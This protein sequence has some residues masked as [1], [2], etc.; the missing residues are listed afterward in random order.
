[1]KLV[2]TRAPRLQPLLDKCQ[3]CGHSGCVVMYD[4]KINQIHP[5]RVVVSSVSLK[6]R[7]CG[8]CAV[9]F[10]ALVQGNSSNRKLHSWLELPLNKEKYSSSGQYSRQ[11]SRWY[12]QNV[13]HKGR[14]YRLKSKFSGIRV[15]KPKATRNYKHY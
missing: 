15:P 13:I 14:P 6:L 3:I 9:C 7:I 5:R 2:S 12:Y 8:A 10:E 11:Y 4:I 1:M